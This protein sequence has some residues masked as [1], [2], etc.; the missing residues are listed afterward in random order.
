MMT[1]KKTKVLKVDES[2]IH[3]AMSL[4]IV[5]KIGIAQDHEVLD[6]EAVPKVAVVA[7]KK[8]EDRVQIARLGKMVNLIAV[9]LQIQINE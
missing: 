5:E 2:I 3:Q 8:T 7:R 9:I 6:L 1:T 4:T